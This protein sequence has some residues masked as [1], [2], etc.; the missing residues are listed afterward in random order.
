MCPA[1]RMRRHSSGSSSDAQGRVEGAGRLEHAATVQRSAAG[2]RDLPR[3]GS[4]APRVHDLLGPVPRRAGRVH[5]H[6]HDGSRHGGHVG[7][8]AHR[9]ERTVE[10]A[11]AEL[12]V[13]VEEQHELAGRLPPSDVPAERRGQRL[14]REQTAP[15]RSDAARPA[16]GCRPPSPEST[17]RISAAGHGLELPQHRAHEPVH[18]PDLV[19]RDDDDGQVGHRRIPRSRPSSRAPPGRRRRSRA[20]GSAAARGRCRSSC[21]RPCPPRLRPDRSQ[22]Q[23]PVGPDGGGRASRCAPS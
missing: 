4:P 15:R 8:L 11:W 7:P 9:S 22:R 13:A 21:A 3:N 5:G 1:S 20:P 10:P 2:V 23:R 14:V 18:V 19:L 12:H 6:V 16:P 17:S